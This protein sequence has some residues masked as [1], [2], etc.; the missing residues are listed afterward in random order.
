MTDE[1]KK[2]L[3]ELLRYKII[4]PKGCRPQ[5]D[6]ESAGRTDVLHAD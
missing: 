6:N 3:R 1:A 5:S 2:K 4:Y